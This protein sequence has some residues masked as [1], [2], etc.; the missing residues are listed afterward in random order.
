MV[1]LSHAIHRTRIPIGAAATDHLDLPAPTPAGV[2]T[3]ASFAKTDPEKASREDL[4]PTSTA[5]TPAVIRAK[6]KASAVR[7]LTE[8]QTPGLASTARASHSLCL[9]LRARPAMIPADNPVEATATNA[10]PQTSDSPS[11]V[12]KAEESSG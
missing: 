6:A 1:R 4:E 2:T 10:I 12:P 11:R 3:K 8:T 9:A 5:Y 7:S